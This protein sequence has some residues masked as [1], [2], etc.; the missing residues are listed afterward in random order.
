MGIV[1]LRKNFHQAKWDEPIIFEYSK[2]GERGVLI[3]GA[4]EMIEREVG[5]VLSDIPRDMI[6]KDSPRLPE[7]SQIRVLR[8]YLRLS[9]ETLGADVNIDIGQG[10]CTMKYS[11]KINEVFTY[12]PKVTE[13][14]PLQDEDSVQGALEIIYKLD[15]MLRELSGFDRFTFQPGGGSHAIYTMA[16]VI[17]AYHQLYGNHYKDEIIT[18]LLSHP[19]DAAASRVKGFKIIDIPPD[20]E[21]GAPDLE[22][23]K[24]AVS[25]HTA[26]LIICNPEDTEIFNPHIREM[27][28]LIHEVG[29]LCAYD[30]ANANGII[31]ILRAVDMD[32]DM[33]FFNLHKTFSSPHGGG[34]PAVGALGVKKSLESF[35]PIPV[36]EYDEKSKRYYFNHDLPHTIGKVREFYGVFP[37]V[38][39]SYAWLMSLG[40]E[41]VKEV[42]RVA[43]LNNN[44]IKTK[45]LREVKGADIS[46]PKTK[47]RVG[48]ARYTFE[49]LVKDTGVTVEDVIRRMNDFGFHLWTS[50]HPWIVPEPFTIEPTESYSK[51]DIDEYI[52]GLK[53]VAEEAYENPEKVKDAPH[54][55]C[56]HKI[57]NVNMLKDPD[58]WAPTWRVYLKNYVRKSER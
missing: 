4:G 48:Q 53:T 20:P 36:I 12:S 24:D 22:A 17:Y 30:G 9:Q 15:L 3:P 26:G 49:K 27:T 23:F 5:D 14:H 29:G 21:T 40:G 7:I 8:H 43:I 16:S 18:T 6:R 34:G 13:L 56:I 57:V 25:E 47:Y 10:T 2:S 54:Q 38:V 35:L 58:K 52:E 46:F 1:K 51:E 28:K 32:F 50:H 45:I 42:S 37:V 33:G 11:P 55:S 44:Y 31:G 41:G 19:S 39:K